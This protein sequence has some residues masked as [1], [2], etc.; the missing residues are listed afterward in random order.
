VYVAPPDFHLLV[1]GH[2]IHLWHGPKENHHRPAINP[3][4]R[5]VATTY[6]RSAVG[7]V[8]SGTLDDGSAG[9]WWIKRYG[10][11]AVVQDPNDAL[12]PEMPSNALKHVDADYV[13]PADTLG[14]KLQMIV[15]ELRDGDSSTD[16]SENL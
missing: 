8:L 4:F 9:L 15:E 12:A 2:H 6:G 13:L 14:R 16:K 5:S 11:I 3:L 7:V 1:N 10:G